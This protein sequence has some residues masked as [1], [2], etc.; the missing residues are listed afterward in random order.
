[1]ADS[2]QTNIPFQA[3]A[4][5]VEQ[6][7]RLSTDQ[8]MQAVDATE[9]QQPSPKGKKTHKLPPPP[10]PGPKPITFNGP[11]KHNFR[12]I[13]KNDFSKS[14][15][16]G[17]PNNGF[18]FSG[19]EETYPDSNHYIVRGTGIITGRSDWQVSP[20]MPMP[21]TDASFG[22]EYSRMQYIGEGREHVYKQ[23]GPK[24]SLNYT[25]AQRQIQDRGI[26]V[27]MDTNELQQVFGDAAQSAVNQLN[28]T[29]PSVGGSDDAA[30]MQYALA[31]QQWMNENMG[32]IRRW[33]DIFRAMFNNYDPSGDLG[34]Y[35][36][37]SPEYPVRTHELGAAISLGAEVRNYSHP[38][39]LFPAAN[40]GFRG[41]LLYFAGK[42]Y[43]SNTYL[44]VGAQFEASLLALNLG[45]PVGDWL[46]PTL[47][48]TVQGGLNFYWGYDKSYEQ[49]NASSLM[50]SANMGLGL[51]LSVPP[52]KK[53]W[54]EKFGRGVKKMIQEIDSKEWDKLDP[55]MD[56]SDL[57]F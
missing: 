5:L 38:V 57:D 52:P 26:A 6:N 7:L 2:I 19:F 17:M 36:Y 15:L 28:T 3:T 35:F 56:G 30:L 22:L 41:S 20:F 11:L 51:R 44:G 13:F 21:A 16:A 32:G 46:P 33:P 9:T 18:S 31:L 39:N 42:H 14:V 49:F 43:Q 29:M 40:L 10:P 55:G 8:Q 37:A 4:G 24:V 34:Y 23:V 45:K 25:T 1:M 12:F 50:G 54:V 53:E 27:T 48:L 47:D